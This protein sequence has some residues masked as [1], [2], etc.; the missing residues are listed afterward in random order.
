ML[1]IQTHS[2]VFGIG[3]AILFTTLSFHFHSVLNDQKIYLSGNIPS[4]MAYIPRAKANESHV[5][6]SNAPIVLVILLHISGR[7]DSE[8]A[9]Q[10][11]WLSN[12]HQSIAVMKFGSVYS[13]QTGSSFLK[14]QNAFKLALKLF[15]QA[16]YISKFDDDSF[17][18]TSNLLEKLSSSG[19]EF[20][21]AGFPLCCDRGVKYGSGGAGYILA[22]KPALKLQTCQPNI[23]PY[24]DV[25]VGLCLMQHG[26]YLTDFVGLHHA[27][28]KQ[29]LEWDRIGHMPDN[30]RGRES[31]EGYEIPISYHYIDPILM[32]EMHLDALYV[33]K[34]LRNSI[35]NNSLNV[36]SKFNSRLCCNCTDST[37]SNHP[38][39]SARAIQNLEG[40]SKNFKY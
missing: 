22:R 13:G 26:I 27:S 23:S 37:L 14:T 35:F 19:S 28:P 40:A 38:A 7:K 12:V 25:G 17:V 1:G 9:V 29:M 18:Y 4:H 15:P 39:H 2:R 8:L 5:V 6:E 30:A 31:I 33:C 10:E 24:E 36:H 16:E 34:W 20:L 3:V 32:R 21:Y 11:T